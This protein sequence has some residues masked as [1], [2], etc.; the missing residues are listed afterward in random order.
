[1]REDGKPSR[2][3]IF[4]GT[5][6]IGKYLVEASVCMVYPTYVYSRPT[7]KASLILRERFRSLGVTIV[8]GTMEDHEK[9]VSTMREVDAVISALAYPQVFEQGFCLPTSV[10][11]KTGYALFSPPPSPF[12]A[13][14][15]KK[16]KI[17][18]AIEAVEIPFTYVS[19]NC[20]GAYIVNLLLHPHDRQLDEVLIYGSGE[21]KAV[22]NYEEDIAKYPI[23][24]ADD[25]RRLTV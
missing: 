6:Y 21:A 25:P 14:L 7:S 23:R 15:E 8:K 11:R 12:E 18:R 3:L 2:V 17:R 16:R 13:F 9:M 20:F 10:V 5:R 4:G 22:L 19:A 24:V 1:M